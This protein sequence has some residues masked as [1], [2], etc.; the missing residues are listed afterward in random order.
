MELGFIY[1]ILVDSLKY[2][3]VVP[4]HYSDEEQRTQSITSYNATHSVS[5]R[6]NGHFQVRKRLMLDRILVRKKLNIFL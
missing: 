4:V 5:K 2:T 6:K 1:M 3:T